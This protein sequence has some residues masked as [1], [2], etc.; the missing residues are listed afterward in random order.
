M[1]VG[2]LIELSQHGKENVWQ[3]HELY[4]YHYG[5]IVGISQESNGAETYRVRFFYK[6]GVVANGRVSV[7]SRHYLNKLFR[8]KVE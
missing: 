2:D 1:K 8:K 7:F 3:T 4:K 6:D 5:L